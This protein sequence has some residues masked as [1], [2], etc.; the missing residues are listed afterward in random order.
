M[1]RPIRQAFGDSEGHLEKLS[2]SNAIRAGGLVFVSGQP[3]VDADGRIPDGIEAQTTVAFANLDAILREAGSGLAHVVKFTTLLRDIG[4]LATIVRVR[5]EVL[6]APYPADTVFQAAELAR[7]DFLVE[8]DA[9][10]V[11]VVD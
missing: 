11:V 9:V 4:D 3:G 10:A 2:F 1:T 7:P 8:I 5:G 6:E